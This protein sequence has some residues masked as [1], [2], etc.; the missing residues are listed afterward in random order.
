MWEMM[1]VPRPVSEYISTIV[2]CLAFEVWDCCWDWTVWRV[3]KMRSS[4][5]KSVHAER[6]EGVGD[7]YCELSLALPI[8]MIAISDHSEQIHNA[9]PAEGKS[10]IRTSHQRGTL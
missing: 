9:S 10:S 2:I 4:T 8:P 1:D 7:L 6:V 5:K 3:V